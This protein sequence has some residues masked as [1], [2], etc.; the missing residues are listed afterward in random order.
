MTER[1]IRA[2]IAKTC[3]K[4]DVRRRR[5]VDAGVLATLAPA[6]LGAGLAATACDSPAALEPLY[7]ATSAGTA[8]TGGTG[9]TGGAVGGGGVGGF[10]GAGGAGGV[11]GAGA[12]GGSGGSGAEGGVAGQ[13]GG[14]GGDGGFAPAY[15]APPAED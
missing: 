5:L 13:G 11:G 1:D 6:V 14:G 15:M 10:G 2:A 12:M 9:G 3:E 8:G 7:M 4:L